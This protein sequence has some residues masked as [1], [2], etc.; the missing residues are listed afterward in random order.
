MINYPVIIL[1]DKKMTEHII[2]AIYPGMMN[3]D[4]IVVT[5]TSGFIGGSLISYIHLL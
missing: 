1:I 2:A 3:H 4:I 5:D